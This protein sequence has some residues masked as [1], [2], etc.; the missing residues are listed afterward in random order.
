MKDSFQ[1]INRPQRSADSRSESA[2]ETVTSA[3]RKTF[4]SMLEEPVP[5]RLQD[6]IERIRDEEVRKMQDKN[7]SGQ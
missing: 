3:L 2:A 5:E 1:D 4:E 7:S 6:L